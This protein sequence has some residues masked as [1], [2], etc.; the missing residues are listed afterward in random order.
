M[1]PSTPQ[2]TLRF[3][4]AILMPLHIHTASL[5]EHTIIGCGTAVIST[6]ALLFGNN[7]LFTGITLYRTC[8]AYAITACVK[9]IADA[10]LHGPWVQLGMTYLLSW[11][12]LRHLYSDTDLTPDVCK[13]TS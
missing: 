10:P 3:A 2:F 4:L 13:L 11:G 9:V 5:H 6:A 7:P 8:V 12:E 1:P